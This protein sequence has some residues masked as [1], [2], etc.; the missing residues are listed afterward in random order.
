M[1]YTYA[2]T[3]DREH[4]RLLQDA[5][6]AFIKQSPRP[7][8]RT[9]PS[10][11]QTIFFFPG[12]MATQ[13][14]RA[15]KKFVDGAATRQTFNYEPVWLTPE[16]FLGGARDLKMYRDRAGTF[17][18]RGDRIIV[19][20]CAVG[21]L[22]ATPHD[23]LV[24][25]CANNNIGLFVFP[26]DWRRRLDETV[27]FFV[28]TFLPSFR[29]QV[30][31]AG[32]PDPLARFSLVGHSFGGMIVNLILRG[33]DPIVAAMTHAITVA[34]P[35]YGYQGQVH[36]W[37][38]GDEYVNG[39]FPLPKD[40]F[41]QEMMETIASLPALYTLHFLDEVTYNNSANHSHDP[42]FPLPSYPSMDVT[43]PNLRADPYN[44]QT[45]GGL[46]RYPAI[47]GFDRCELDYARAQFQLMAGPMD[48]TLL[49]N[50]YNIRGVRTKGDEQTPIS[51]TK[52]GVTW[53]WIQTNFD[54]TDHSPIVEGEDVQ[55][56]GTQPAWTARL[57]TND[58]RRVITVRGSDIEHICMMNHALVLGAIAAILGVRGA[59]MSRRDTAPPEPASDENVVKFLRWLSEHPEVVRRWPR[60]NDPK[61][62]KFIPQQFKKSIGAIARRILMDIMK[63]PAPQGLGG[64]RPRTSRKKKR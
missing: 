27:K 15:T 57:A 7:L 59:A 31:K 49:Q 39:V 56:D 25:W 40:I 21:I 38:E 48:P 55:G 20:D 13:L 43:D 37:F 45:N 62:R 36:R 33:N 44:P 42:D 34:T 6:D 28:G 1:T 51:D 60:L 29:E 16:T 4:L 64:P 2:D 3:R 8:G 11:R 53:N 9:S 23:G 32:R 17:R 26:W 35:F 18:D 63:R 52:G 22:G 19:S 30:L 10:P 41:K 61:L 54:S 50:F 46:V 58:P 14:T 47:T 24:A 12:G 5:I